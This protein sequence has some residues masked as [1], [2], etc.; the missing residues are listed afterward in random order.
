MTN[1]LRQIPEELTTDGNAVIN[2][3]Q[4]LAGAIGT[5]VI[6]T[7][8]ASSQNSIANDM[9]FSTMVGSQNAFLLLAILSALMLCCS[10]SVFYLLQKQKK[11]QPKQ[12]DGIGQLKTAPQTR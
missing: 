9:A 8:V 7:I 2:T 1:G 5:S 11:G 10:Y 6:T 4:Q 12:T 3:L